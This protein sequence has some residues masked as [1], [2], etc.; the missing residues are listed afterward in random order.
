[1]ESEENRALRMSWLIVSNEE[2]TD[3]PEERY[4]RQQEHVERD[5]S[6]N[7]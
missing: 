1:M 5:K 6:L 2:I 4:H 3:L 7:H